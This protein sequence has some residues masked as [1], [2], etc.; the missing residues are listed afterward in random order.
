M[1]RY[2]VTIAVAAILFVPPVIAFPSLSCNPWSFAGALPSEAT[3]ETVTAVPEGGSFG[4]GADDVAYPVN[5]TGLPALC[6]VIVKVQSSAN[7]SYRFGLFLP[8]AWNGKFL[9]I[10]NGGFSGGINWLDMGPGPH[11]GMATVST[12]MGHNSTAEITAWALDNP[13]ARTDWGWRATHGSVILGKQLTQAYYGGT[14]ITYSFYNGCSTGGRQGL[15]EL[16]EFPDSFDGALIGAPAWWTTHLNSYLTQLGIYNLP[17]TD[18]KHISTAHMA[19]I[20]DEVV[21]QCDGVDGLIDGIVSSPELCA[22]SFTPL[23]CND[24]TD[25][26]TTNPD[27]CLNP[28][29]VQT[30][31]NVYSDVYSPNGT[32]LYNGLTL[33]SEDQWFILLGGPQP[34]PFGLGYDRDF[35]YNN[36]AWN[37]TDFNLSRTIALAETTH[38]YGATA[39]HFDISAFKQRGAKLLL[40]HGLADGLVPTRGS[41]YYYNETIAAFN[42]SRAAVADFFR[43]FLVPGMQH[44][45]STPVGAPWNIGG[46]FQAGVMGPGYWS[47][48][49]FEGS[50]RHDALLALVDWVER[51]EAVESIVATAWRSPLN[52]SS[53]VLRQRPLCAW[54]AK[55]V[56]D[57]FGDEDEAASWR[58][59]G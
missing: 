23:L 46:S 15:R 53:G 29:Q 17:V 3:I 1:T 57:G 50:K 41:E 14:N 2:M 26:Q 18:P 19:V 49:G 33:S 4:G 44:C 40:Y 21:R 42:V 12:D 52:A 47:V 16:Q 55:A 28:A 32:F 30:A 31:K 34:S 45:W 37:W 58:C 39:A 38:P 10:G 59:A 24:T 27:S 8:T 13:E 56:W 5:P 54:P 36:Q 11:Y 51:G 22:F 6:A 35:L 9:T 25:T 7:S 48:P 43:M 20:A